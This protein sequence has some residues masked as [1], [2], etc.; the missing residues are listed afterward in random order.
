MG[1]VECF[2]FKMFTVKTS[3]E[4]FSVNALIVC[5]L[6]LL[7]LLF[8]KTNE[9]NLNM[10]GKIRLQSLESQSLGLFSQS[11]IPSVHT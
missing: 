2:G 11:A 4:P 6:F 9:G 1:V 7:L 8:L 3:A 10:Q 5:L